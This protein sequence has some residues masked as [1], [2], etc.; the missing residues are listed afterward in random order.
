MRLGERDEHAHVVGG[1]QDLGEAQVRARL[2][3][4]V[5]GVNH[6]DAEAL[7][8]LQALAARLVTGQR[9]ADQGIVERDGGQEDARA[10]QVE[11]AAVD[12]EL[13]EPESHVEGGIEHLALFASSNERLSGIHVPRRVQVPEPVGLPV[14]V[15]VMRP[16][17]R[18]VAVKALLVNS[19]TSRPSCVIRARRE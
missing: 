11:V 13:A 5:V 16:S 12:P 15:N 1:P 7:E 6:V 10:V 2:A 18:S 17:S 14:P 3:A 9:G 19:V 8:P 4:V